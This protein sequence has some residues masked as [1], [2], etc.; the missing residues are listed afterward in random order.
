MVHKSS[1]TLRPSGGPLATAL[2]IGR[3]VP[4]PLAR[5]MTKP[6]E[7]TVDSRRP[8]PPP[9]RCAVCNAFPRNLH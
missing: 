7:P 5:C 6:V 4:E 2:E 8:Q 1:Q 9:R 3:I